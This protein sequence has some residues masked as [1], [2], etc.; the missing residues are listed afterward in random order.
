MQ[1]FKKF[2]VGLLA[3]GTLVAAQAQALTNEEAT[4]LMQSKGYIC[5]SC[6]QVEVKVLGPSYKEV[7]AKRAGADQAVKDQL[8]GYIKAGK[9]ANLE[10]GQIPMPPNPTVTD[11]DAAALVDWILSLQ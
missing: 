2:A 9:A 5:L 10:Y 8:I 3:A 11:E 6:H 4:A 7:A 1:M